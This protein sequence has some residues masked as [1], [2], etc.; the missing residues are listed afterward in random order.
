MALAYTKAGWN[1]S[2]YLWAYRQN[3]E[4]MQGEWWFGLKQVFVALGWEVRG[5]LKSGGSVLHNTNDVFGAW[6]GVDPWT[7]GADLKRSVGPYYIILRSPQT[8]GGNAEIC[9][10]SQ[11]AS[12]NSAYGYFHFMYYSH[13]AG[14][15]AA[16]GGTDGSGNGPSGATVPPLA[17]DNLVLA[18]INAGNNN[19]IDT[20]ATFSIYGAQSS[21]N[22]ST[23]IV[24]QRQ[25][26][27]HNW[28]SFEHLDNAHA[29][30]DHSGRVIA[31]RWSNSIDPNDAVMLNTFYTSAIYYGQVS[32]ITRGLYTGT[33]SY[34]NVGHQSL[35]IVQQDNKMVV[36]PMDL[37]NN[38][39]TEKGYYGTI[40]DLYWGNNNHFMQ[41]LGDS[42]GGAPNWLSGGSIVT[43]W[44]GV[45]PE[46]LPRVY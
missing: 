44:D 43:P 36:A 17:S 24:I 7:S 18:T 33:S 23:R 15:G 3:L 21:D 37:Y 13:N 42:V 9:I 4:Q 30:L 38:T 25:R 19:G 16:N 14:F 29:N 32:G 35:H 20:G 26:V 22:K 1:F 6:P 46:P 28:F 8:E 27:S 39:L 41:L 31:T 34:A 10:G 40:P 2:K 11:Y 12:N 45:T 5:G